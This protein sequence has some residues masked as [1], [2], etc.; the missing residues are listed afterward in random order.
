MDWKNID[1]KEAADYLRHDFRCDLASWFV[2]SHG[3]WRGCDII[4]HMESH[5]N[6][7]RPEN[8]MV[9]NDAR[10]SYLFASAFRVMLEMTQA[11]LKEEG[12]DAAAEL[13]KKKK[14]PICSA[15]LGGFLLPVSDRVREAELIPD[16]PK[17]IP[18]YDETCQFFRKIMR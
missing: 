17:H 1:E 3:T 7:H 2:I 16:A 6:V 10:R 13:C 5:F 9:A 14:W 18:F 15:G 8:R 12:E 4:L 11:K